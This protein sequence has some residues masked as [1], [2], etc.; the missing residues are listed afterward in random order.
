MTVYF[1]TKASNQFG[2]GSKLI[3]GLSVKCE[4]EDYSS[5]LIIEQILFKNVGKDCET[6]T[7]LLFDTTGNVHSPHPNCPPNPRCKIVNRK[8]KATVQT[9]RKGF[10][11][12]VDFHYN[13]TFIHY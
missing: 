6:G 4:M 11:Q 12:F 1:V 3:P 10:Q 7:Q 8:T 13:L 9:R 2:R 5:W